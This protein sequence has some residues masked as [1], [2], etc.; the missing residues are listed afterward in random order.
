MWLQKINHALFLGLS[1]YISNSYADIELERSNQITSQFTHELAIYLPEK[2]SEIGFS[3]YDEKACKP[4]VDLDEKLLSVYQR[5]YKKLLNLAT[6]TNTHD[7]FIDLKLLNEYIQNQIKVL[8]FNHAEKV[9]PFMPGTQ[10]VFQHLKFLMSPQAND[11]RKASAVKRFH[12]YVVSDT[13]NR[14]QQYIEAALRKYPA[15]KALYPSFE[16]LSYYLQNSPI[17]L[18]AVKE[19]LQDSGRDGWKNDFTQYEKQAEAFDLFIKETLLPHARQTPAMP[20][21]LYRQ[22]LKNYGV[23]E[24][25]PEAM[26]AVGKQD[27]A[28]LY[29]EYQALAQKI[30]KKIT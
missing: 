2:A 23:K 11:A 8:R 5:W 26:I 14:Y 15:D 10:V 29:Q 22:Q 24:A 9:I 21:A 17:Y 4:T 27:Y 18:H 28:L 3:E 16:E 13:L 1:L 20:E 25:N 12:A 19:L 30:A 6:L 7:G